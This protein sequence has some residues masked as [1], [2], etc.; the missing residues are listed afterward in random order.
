MGNCCFGDGED[1]NAVKVQQPSQAR[2]VPRQVPYLP[3]GTTASGRDIFLVEGP[4]T[5]EV[6]G[7]ATTV[8]TTTLSASTSLLSFLR[9]TLKLTGTKAMCYQAG[10][11]AC[12]V[13]ATFAD[14]FSG[15]VK[16]RAVNACTTPLLGGFSMRKRSH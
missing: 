4:V 12:M 11:G 1:D 2:G 16:T 5:I 6:N 8:D 13:T 9:D 14:P 7:Q 10:C 3:S 15:A